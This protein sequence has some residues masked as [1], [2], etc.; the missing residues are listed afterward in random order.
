MRTLSLEPEF[1]R[2]IGRELREIRQEEG[3]T[4]EALGEKLGISPQAVGELERGETGMTL[5]RLGRVLK[6]LGRRGELSLLEAD[7]PTASAEPTLKRLRLAEKIVDILTSVDDGVIRDIYLY[8]STA[9]GTARPDSDLD[10]MIVVKTDSVDKHNQRIHFYNE[11]HDVA[12]ETGVYVSLQMSTVEDWDHNTSTF[13]R[14]VI[15]R[16]IR[17]YHRSGGS[18]KT[19]E[20]SA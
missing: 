1:V 20:A 16:G 8:G 3:M 4:L 18:Q 2:E 13:K 12:Y 14:E 5:D 6:A 11:I 17:L 9:H 7:E 19:L 15:D 10:L